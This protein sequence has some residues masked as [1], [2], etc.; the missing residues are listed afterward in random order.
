M[1]RVRFPIVVKRGSSEVKIYRD[2]KLEGTYYRVVYYLGSKR[3]RLNFSDF[4]EAETE[5]EAKA[6][7][8]SR[9]DMDAVQVSKKDRDELGSAREVIRELLREE[10][11]FDSLIMSDSREKR[12]DLTLDTVAREYAEARKLLNGVP[13]IEAASFYARHHGKALKRK[14]V[15]LAVN[16]MIERK[17]TKG[18]SELYLADLRYRLGVFSQAFHCDV[19]AITPD[20]VAMFFDGLKLSPR[21]HNNFLYALRTFFRFAQKHDWLSKEVD[22]LSRVEKRNGK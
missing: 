21:S 20:D 10:S 17:K 18:V 22:L 14:N 8:L 6:S 1:K 19:N 15:A 2:R 4:E 5:A 16:E 11:G 7:Q 3:H 13:L 12:F 9:G